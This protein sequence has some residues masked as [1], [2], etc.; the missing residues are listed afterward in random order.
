[1]SPNSHLLGATVACK[2]PLLRSLIQLV[3][4]AAQFIL[5]NGSITH[6]SFKIGNRKVMILT[7]AT[8]M[9]GYFCVIMMIS[10]HNW[11]NP[12]ALDDNDQ[13]H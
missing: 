3:D 10:I 9:P 8:I 7:V 13:N 1:M 6:A 5:S 11:V 4:E 2:L 12:D